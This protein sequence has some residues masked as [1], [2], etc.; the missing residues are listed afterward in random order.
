MKKFILPLAAVIM[1]AVAACSGGS[2]NDPKQVAKNFF[3]AFESMDIDKAALYAT[4]DS[5]SMLDM[6]KMGMNMAQLNMDSIKKEKAKQ[7]IEFSDPVIN[8][9]EATIAV[10]VDGKDKTDF[11]LKKEEGQWKVAFDKNTLMKTGMEKRGQQGDAT[12]EEVDAAI[13]GMDTTIGS[14]GDT[15]IAH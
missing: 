14:I 4:K 9:D 12:Q 6:M 10:T 1:L 8:G 7:K 13:R 5:K 2:K 11:K 15:G 3:E